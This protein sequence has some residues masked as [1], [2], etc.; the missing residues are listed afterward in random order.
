LYQGTAFSR[1]AKLG[2]V[3]ALAAAPFSAHFDVAAYGP[4]ATI[5]TLNT[6]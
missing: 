1:A 3:E 6:A 4:L 5:D 2:T